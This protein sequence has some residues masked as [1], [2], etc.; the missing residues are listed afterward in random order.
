M[1]QLPPNI[2]PPTEEHVRS[3][4]ETYHFDL[5]EEE[6]AAYRALI[7]EKLGFCARIDELA[8][9]GGSRWRGERDPG[10]RA[11]PE[12]DPENAIVTYCRVE[13]ADSGPLAGYEVGIKDNIAVA[14][15]EMTSG[16]RVM[17]GYR[18]RDDATVVERL[19]DAGATI[20]AKTNMSEMAVSGSGELGLGGPVLNPRDPAYLAGGSSSGSAVAVVTGDVDVALGTDQAGSVRT[21]AAWSGCVGLKPTHGLVPYRGASPL[22]HSFDHIGPMTGSVADAARVL[23]VVAGVDPD[24]PRQRAVDPGDY[25]GALGESPEGL[26]IGVLAEGFELGG[27]EPAVDEAVHAAV[28]ELEALGADA[29][30]VSIPWHRDGIFVWLAVEHEEAAMMWDAES[31]GYFVDGRYDTDR[32][33][34]FAKARRARADEFGPTVKLKCLLGRYLAEQFHGRYHDVGQNLRADLRGAYDDA[35]TDFDALL[36]PTTPVT[37]FELE[38]DLTRAEL[39]DR[40]QGKEGRTRNTMPFNMTGH[41][42]MSVPCGTTDGLPIGMMLVG[43]QFDEETILRIGHAFERATEWTERGF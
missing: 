32:A 20:T 5:S 2:R 43:N 38:E 16:S 28:D 19:L 14:D 7:E 18:P 9:R 11:T 1:S 31:T 10:R 4:A 12:E 42:A 40:A 34:A 36:M 39:I 33:Q 35:L 41:P 15:V 25:V 21:P 37:A 26:R 27:D 17:A 13:G 22:G 29:E 23:S 30:A 6:L 3:I 8:D 24:D